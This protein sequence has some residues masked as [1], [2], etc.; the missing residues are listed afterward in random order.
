MLYICIMKAYLK[1]IN[2]IIIPEV[3]TSLVVVCNDLGVSYDSAA[4]GKRHWLTDNKLIEIKELEIIKIK[5]R[6]KK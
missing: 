3:H 5:G 4:R 2:G 6:G 1:I